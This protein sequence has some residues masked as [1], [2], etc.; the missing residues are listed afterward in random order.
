MWPNA[1]WRNQAFFSRHR[2]IHLS[3]LMQ[4][5]GRASTAPRWTN[6]QRTLEHHRKCSPI[7]QGQNAPASTL[8]KA[9]SPR[10]MSMS[11]SAVR[12]SLYCRRFGL[13]R[14][15]LRSSALQMSNTALLK[16]WV[17]WDLLSFPRVIASHVWSTA[18][19]RERHS[20][21]AYSEWHV[22]KTD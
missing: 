6:G 18:S 13:R 17:V 9:W 22:I 5:L 14:F 2:E 12:L 10:A 20:M 16:P 3:D 8:L 7:S 21:I 4:L 1:K 19:P 15:G 11:P